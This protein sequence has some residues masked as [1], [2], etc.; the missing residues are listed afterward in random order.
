MS[1]LVSAIIT[2]YMRP[3]NIVF[4]AIDSVFNQ[5]YSNI[6]VI[7][8]DDSPS[9]YE[10][11]KILQNEV[12]KYGGKIIYIQHISNMGACAAR[13]TG[14]SVA[15]GKYVAFLDDDD[16]WLP[17]KI[18]QQ[19][20]LFLDEQTALVYCGKMVVNDSTGMVFCDELNAYAGY[21]YDKL[22]YNNFIGSTSFP[23]IRKRVL[24]EV[25]GFDPLMQSA[26]DYDVWLR[27][28]RNYKVDFV[29][30]PL[31]KY[32]V[33]NGERISTNYKARIS[34]QE[35]L[36]QKNL[37]YLHQI[38]EAW[39]WRLLR[40]SLQYSKDM[41]LIRAIQVWMNALA[42]QPLRIITN[43]D[44]LIRILFYYL[45]SKFCMKKL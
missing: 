13:N 14:L 42:K 6:E 25:G 9:Y 38:P 39:W 26:Q 17:E 4:R 34:G 41:Q 1:D 40:L 31:V 35:R 11:R 22:I 36:I 7:V 2:T 43:I 21:I 37:D 23:L 3:P 45:K 20:S 28:T 24:I 12:A 33:H 32:H 5:T 19:V 10:G 30:Q 15:N 16:E 27:L 8:V 44:Y 29:R 18:E